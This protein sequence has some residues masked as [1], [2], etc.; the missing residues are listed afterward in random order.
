MA[1]VLTGDQVVF[2]KDAPLGY[3]QIGTL[4]SSVGL[5][6]IPQNARFA[7]IQCTGQDVRW[8]DDGTAP[9]ASVGMMLTVGTSLIYNG[10]LKAIRFIQTS[11]TALLNYAFYA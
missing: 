2:G 7:L 1:E 4:T 5:T 8:R 11:A 3:Q 10:D 9:T 6:S